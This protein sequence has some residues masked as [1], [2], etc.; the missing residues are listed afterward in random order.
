VAGRAL[1]DVVA[2]AATLFRGRPGPRFVGGASSFSSL[3]AR[4]LLAAVAAAVDVR[5]L[6]G[7]MVD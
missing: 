3:R 4:F 6:R 1:A 2:S 7:G 5:A